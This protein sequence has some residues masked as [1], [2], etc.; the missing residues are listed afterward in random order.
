MLKTKTECWAKIMSNLATANYVTV[1]LKTV[2]QVYGETWY[3]EPGG[4]RN[5]RLEDFDYQ[6]GGRLQSHLMAGD[7]NAHNG[8]WG[9]D[10]RGENPLEWT[11]VNG[12]LVANNRNMRPYG[13]RAT[14]SKGVGVID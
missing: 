10:E 9:D 4:N 3:D 6:G 12:Y 5:R 7:A 8:A 13:R 2:P 1:R 11:I 14:L